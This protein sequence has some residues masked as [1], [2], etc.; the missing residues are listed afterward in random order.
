M[1]IEITRDQDANLI[2]GEVNLECDIQLAVYRAWDNPQWYLYSVNFTYGDY[3]TSVVD[4]IDNSYPIP[5]DSPLGI[6]LSRAVGREAASWAP[7]L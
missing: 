7:A 1:R 3:A 5:A 4:D 6:E 2:N